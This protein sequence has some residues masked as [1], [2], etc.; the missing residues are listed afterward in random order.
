MHGQEGASRSYPSPFSTFMNIDNGR[1]K[2]HNK[3]QEQRV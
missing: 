1:F 2:I 3:Q